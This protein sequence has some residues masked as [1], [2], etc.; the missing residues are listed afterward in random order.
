M[1]ETFYFVN[2]GRDNGYFAVDDKENE[3]FFV[4]F[5]MF[6]TLIFFCLL[7]III[8]EYEFYVFCL[9]S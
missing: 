3:V 2:V 5:S 8:D 1:G 6:I 4:V 9:S 7:S